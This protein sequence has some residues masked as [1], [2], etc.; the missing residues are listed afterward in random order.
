M[1]KYLKLEDDYLPSLHILTLISFS[2]LV[3]STPL[4]AFQDG[5][6]QYIREYFGLFWHLSMYFFIMKLPTPKWGKQAGTYWIILDVLSGLLYLNNFYGISGDL[7]LGIITMSLTLPNVIRYAA[8]IF[9]GIWL[10][11]SSLTTSNKVIR[12][13]GLLAGLLIMIY[14]FISPFAPE[15]IL[16]LNS[17]FMYIW[18]I[19]IVRGKY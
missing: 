1:K 18:F 14:S 5:I 9:E 16:A 2:L 19:W 4:F 12:I 7:S 10:I 3:L 17:P 15:W 8:H 11:S 13:C 6:G